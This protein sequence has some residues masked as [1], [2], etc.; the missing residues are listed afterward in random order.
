MLH[1]RIDTIDLNKNIMIYTNN[2]ISLCRNFFIWMKT[3]LAYMTNFCRWYFVD[4]S[5]I[6]FAKYLKTTSLTENLHQ[7]KEINR[8]KSTSTLILSNEIISIMSRFIQL[9]MHRCHVTRWD[10]PLHT[11]TRKAFKWNAVRC[12]TIPNG[13]IL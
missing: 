10:I 2:I 13:E 9:N 7:G 8:K 1:F 6:Y 3:N 5:S 4:F 12:K 11:V